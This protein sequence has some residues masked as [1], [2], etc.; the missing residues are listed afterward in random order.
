MFLVSEQIFTPGGVVL[1]EHIRNKCLG[2]PHIF[3]HRLIIAFILSIKYETF[4]PSPD[5]KGQEN[6]ILAGEHSFRLDVIKIEV[7]CCLGVFQEASV[8]IDP[9]FYHM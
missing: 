7:F 1:S 2:F 8:S 6:D 9:R 3:I 4:K 5:V